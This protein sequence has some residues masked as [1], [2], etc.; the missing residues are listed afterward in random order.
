LLQSGG[1]DSWKQK[2]AIVLVCVEGLNHSQL[3]VLYQ[4]DL[5]E[6]KR[7]TETTRTDVTQ[8]TD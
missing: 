2:V 5:V 7:V 8:I 4:N 6:P 1:G 3:Q